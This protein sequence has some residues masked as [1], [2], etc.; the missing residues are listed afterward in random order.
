[1]E[2]GIHVSAAQNKRL[3]VENEVHWVLNLQ[4]PY[5]RTEELDSEQT[6]VI[7]NGLPGGSSWY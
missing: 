4:I 6:L 3:Q 1:M 2:I 5:Q 7:C